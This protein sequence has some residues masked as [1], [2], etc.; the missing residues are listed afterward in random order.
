VKPPI[1]FRTPS[2]TED[3]TGLAAGVAAAPYCRVVAGRGALDLAAGTLRDGRMPTV[4]GIAIRVPAPGTT[5]RTTHTE[6]RLNHSAGTM[7]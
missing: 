3:G 5:N 4:T 6:N 2:R 1:E 7:F